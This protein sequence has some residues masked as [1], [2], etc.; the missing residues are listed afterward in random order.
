[1]DKSK[2]LKFVRPLS[3]EKDDPASASKMNKYAI[4]TSGSKNMHVCIFP[5][6][7]IA[8]II[9]A[10]AIDIGTENSNSGNRKATRQKSFLS[11]F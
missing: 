8:G 9:G 5:I 2:E 11:V 3:R 10:N 7:R 6:D 1:M 4:G